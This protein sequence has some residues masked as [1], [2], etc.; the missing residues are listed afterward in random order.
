MLKK[1]QLEEV[2]LLELHKWKIYLDKDWRMKI[3]AILIQVLN[4]NTKF[5]HHYVNHIK[6]INIIWYI[7]N[8]DGS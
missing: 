5:F 7:V 8:E 6:S 4:E 2:K 1:E 3:R